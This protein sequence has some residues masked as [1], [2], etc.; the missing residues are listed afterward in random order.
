MQALVCRRQQLGRAWL[1]WADLP[2]QCLGNSN[3]PVYTSIS[4]L[5]RPR[6]CRQ[7][8]QPIG[9]SRTKSATPPCSTRQLSWRKGWATRGGMGTAMKGGQ[10]RRRAT[11]SPR[12]AMQLRSARVLLLDA[13][14]A[15]AGE[16]ERS[17]RDVARQ[18]NVEVERGGFGSRRG[19]E[20]VARSRKAPGCLSSKVP[21]LSGTI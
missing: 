21:T 5:T 4:Y 18:E 15:A 6:V 1:A 20:A 8:R 19:G 12:G 10:G 11:P 13:V 16:R 7:T 17:C 3:R 2:R 14:G 9:L